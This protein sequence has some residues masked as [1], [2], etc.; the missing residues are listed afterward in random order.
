[1][2]L[3]LE[4]VR[5]IFSRFNPCSYLPSVATG[6]WKQFQYLNIVL[7][8]KIGPLFWSYIDAIKIINVLAF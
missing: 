5:P 6:D 4:K 2:P 1:M 7:N 8:K 3:K